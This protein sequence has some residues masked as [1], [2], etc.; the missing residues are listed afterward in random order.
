[1]AR[2]IARHPLLNGRVRLCGS[3]VISMRVSQKASRV[4]PH[5]NLHGTTLL[6]L[7]TL[8]GAMWNENLLYVKKDKCDK[9]VERMRSLGRY[10]NL[11][12]RCMYREQRIALTSELLLFHGFDR[13]YGLFRCC[14]HHATIHVFPFYDDGYISGTCYNKAIDSE[15]CFNSRWGSEVFWKRQFV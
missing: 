7:L 1:M 9:C 8:C 12:R 4:T 3:C 14:W 10:R 11:P 13:F 5:W 15:F 6:L 2:L